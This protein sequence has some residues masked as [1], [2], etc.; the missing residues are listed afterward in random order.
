[1]VLAGEQELALPG[2]AKPGRPAPAPVRLLAPPVRPCPDR[3]FEAPGA[4]GVNLATCLGRAV[5]AAR[6]RGAPMPDGVGTRVKTLSV[7]EAC[8]RAAMS[9]AT[10]YRLE[11]ATIGQR[12]SVPGGYAARLELWQRA[13]TALGWPLS[14]LIIAAERLQAAALC[15]RVQSLCTVV[16]AALRGAGRR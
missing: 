7:G 8:Q 13:A 11:S 3:E 6:Q 12:D 1:M 15:G 14:S 4:L 9:R 5:W 16:F 10:W 2:K